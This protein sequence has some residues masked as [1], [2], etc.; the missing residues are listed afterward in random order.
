MSP[1]LRFDDRREN[2]VDEAVELA[3]FWMERP[4]RRK[5]CAAP[6]V[7]NVG[8]VVDDQR[9]DLP[10]RSIGAAGPGSRS[11]GREND[12]CRGCPLR[13]KRREGTLDVRSNLPGE[14]GIIV[15]QTESPLTKILGR[16]QRGKRSPGWLAFW[17]SG[18]SPDGG[19]DNIRYHLGIDGLLRANA[20]NTVIEMPPKPGRRPRDA[21]CYSPECVGCLGVYLRLGQMRRFVVDGC[22]TFA[23][24]RDAPRQNTARM[25]LG[26][27]VLEDFPSHAKVF[28]PILRRGVTDIVG[29]V[30][31][32]RAGQWHCAGH[33][34]HDDTLDRRGYRLRRTRMAVNTARRILPVT[35]LRRVSVSIQKT[36]RRRRRRNDE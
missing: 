20:G 17:M 21:L 26:E 27:A 23:S 28:W 34:A 14:I 6:Y 24:R 12:R 11:H 8:N 33:S 15:E 22:G 3:F 29:Q 2:E 9:V 10:A 35:R 4:Q 1:R 13:P 32:P 31:R 16:R 25:R 7:S 19:L 36:G 18:K 5:P 30:I